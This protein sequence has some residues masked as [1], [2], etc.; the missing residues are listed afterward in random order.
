[1]SH[2]YW[3]AREARV[4]KEIMRNPDGEEIRAIPQQKF[5]AQILSLM[6]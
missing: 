3:P 2:C 4:R 5:H 1:M 6:G